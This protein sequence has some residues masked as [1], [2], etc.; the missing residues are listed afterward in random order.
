MG[1]L[2]KLLVVAQLTTKMKSIFTTIVS[3]L[4]IARAVSQSLPQVDLG[5]E[6]HQAI[7]Y[8]VRITPDGLERT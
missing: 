7:T 5:Y 2:L 3:A 6:I 1:E 8:N 4:S